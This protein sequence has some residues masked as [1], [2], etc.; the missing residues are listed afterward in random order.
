MEPYSDRVTRCGDGKYRWVYE[1]PMLK[2]PTILLT[3]LTLFLLCGLAPVGILVLIALPLTLISYGI[4]AMN[5]GWTYIVLFEMDETGITHLQ[6]PRQFP[7]TQGFAI[8][9]HCHQAKKS[10]AFGAFAKRNT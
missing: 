6:Q 3:T 7:K 2:N 5:Y 8:A 4:L 9:A 10:V 1:Y